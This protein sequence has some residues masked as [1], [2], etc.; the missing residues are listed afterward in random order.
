MD[1]REL[2]RED[3]NK[4]DKYVYG[5]PLGTLNHLSGWRDVMTNVYGYKTYYLYAV[6]DNQVIGVLPLIEVKG[7]IFGHYFTSIPGGLCADTDQAASALCEQAKDFLKHEKGQYLILRDCQR[8]WE[9]P[10]FT[11]NC[12]HFSLTV[13]LSSD[14]NQIRSKINKRAQLLVDKAVQANLDVLRGI[15][16]LESFYPAYSRS[17]ADK[18]TPTLGLKFFREV[19]AQFSENIDLFAIRNDKHMM[20]GGF[21][22]YFKDMVS[23]SWGGMMRQYYH[24]YPNHLLYWETMKHSA[25]SGYKQLD[26]GRSAWESGTFKF[27]MNWGA[28]P[29]PLFQL[30]YLNGVQKPPLVGDRISENTQYKVYMNVWRHLPST[31]TEKVGPWLRKWKPFG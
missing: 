8:K 28:E 27:K 2:V 9:L 14:L 10:E 15:E 30:I 6:E 7:L 12:D 22:F 18:G 25:E 21:I 5:S 3:K 4:W 29:K 20:G 23:C 31:I 26:F 1:I 13:E 19:V 24:L 17:M 11:I 16:Y